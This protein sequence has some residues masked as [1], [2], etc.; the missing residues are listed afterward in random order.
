M[1]VPRLPTDLRDR[2]AALPL[3]RAPL[4]RAGVL[5]ALLVVL[6]VAGQAFRPG[7]GDSRP[8]A[9]RQH[10]Q[11]DLEKRSAPPTGWTGGR[12]LALLLLAG[13]GGGAW[14]L[15]RRSAPAAARS[16]ALDVIETQTL[17]PGQSLRLVA[18]GDDVL[19]LSASSEGIRLLRSWPRDRF[20]SS[21]G[22][23]L[24]EGLGVEDVPADDRRAASFAALLASAANAPRDAPTDTQMPV[25]AS[26]TAGPDS[27]SAAPLAEATE[28]D[29]TGPALATI[30]DGPPG[31]PARLGEAEPALAVADAPSPAPEW[32]ADVLASGPLANP[33]ALGA[34]PAPGGPAVLSPEPY[35]ADG[36][37]AAGCPSA[38]VGAAPFSRTVAERPGLFF[39]APPPAP[40]ALRQFQAADD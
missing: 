21:A 37:G 26:D 38:S 11:A 8:P 18:C 4:R 5:T 7:R 20:E 36:A 17:G 14:L 3:D 24:A 22:G 12:V 2:L 25:S 6:L 29:A 35:A 27:T 10:V 28:P 19:L 15:H 23:A 32:R 9:D 31:Y 33:G 39:P 16:S 40:R 1:T 34:A 13:G 30:P